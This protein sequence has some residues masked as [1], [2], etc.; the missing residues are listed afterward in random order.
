MQIKGIIY[1]KD[2]TLFDFRTTWDVWSWQLITL[3]AKGNPTQ[4]KAIATAA[5][6][7]LDNQ[8]FLP[9]SPIIAG[10][11]RQAAE[12]FAPF[13]P[14]LSIHELEQILKATSQNVPQAQ[15]VPLKEY[16]NS[17][18]KAGLKLAVMTNDSYEVAITQLTKA[19]VLEKL[20]CIIGFDSG[21]GEKPDPDP[22]LAIAHMLHLEPAQM[23]MVG[24]S[25][26]DIIAGRAAGMK[27]IALLTGLANREELSPFA[28]VVLQDIG[29]IPN[30]LNVYKEE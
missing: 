7:D 23:V 26:H 20:D 22:L 24:D 5:H 30:Y 9:T 3:F 14:E 18:R 27:T 1:D 8:R 17:L 10:T 15:V 25:Q 4:A 11:N 6:Y 16:F 21:Y 28:D 12:I 19:Q 29:E 2:G 13:M